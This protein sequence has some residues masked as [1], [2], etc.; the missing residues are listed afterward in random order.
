MAGASTCPGD[1]ELAGFLARTISAVVRRAIEEHL[2]PCAR[3]REV[4]G[5]LAA[6]QPSPRARGAAAPR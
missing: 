2:D 6:T 5:H 4:V 1:D 3:C